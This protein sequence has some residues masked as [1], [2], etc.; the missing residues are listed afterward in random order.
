MAALLTMEMGDT[1][2]TYKN[3]ADCRERGVRILP[4]DVNQSG[5][6][7]TAVGD[8]IRFGLG[9]V[10]GVGGKAIETILAARTTPFESFADFCRRVRGPV[11][12]K[13]VVESL[14]Q[15]GALDSLGVTRARLVAAAEDMLRWAERVEREANSDQQSLF[16]RTGDSTLS[17]PPAIPVVPEWSDQ[18]ML[19]AEKDA[20]GIFL[21]GHPLDKFDRDLSRLTNA[22]TGTLAARAHQERVTVAGVI[23][24][25]KTKNSKK[26][27]RYATFSLEDKEGVVEVIAW[28]EAYRKFETTIHGD[29]P[30]LIAGSL[31]KRDAAAARGDD[32]DALGEGGEAPR[33]R[34]QIIAD[35]IRPLAA[36]REQ[37]VRQVHLQVSADSLTDERLMR[38]R[39]TLAQHRGSC[40]AYLHVIVPGSSE[41]VIELPESLRV[42]PSEA[43]LDAVENIFGTGVAILR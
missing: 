32:A 18:E 36:A 4:P 41:T 31:D 17:D 21:T 20:I 30:V 33:E 25:V 7:F 3:I 19:R 23:H 13:R 9:A 27:D 34:S 24:T 10:R 42:I 14:V 29:E 28:P 37:S 1:D 8:D 16:G 11:I 40:P 5:A 15:C 38:L 39:D 43:M 35:E 2:K 12:N 6:D 26:G 22:S